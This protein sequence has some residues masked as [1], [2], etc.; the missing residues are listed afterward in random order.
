VPPLAEDDAVA[1]LLAR[2]A[3]LDVALGRTDIVAELC[4][5][6][7]RLPLALEL[8]AARTPLFTPAQLV[9]RLSQRLDLLKGGR[10]ATT[11][12]PRSCASG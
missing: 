1:L 8:A 9:E 5:R 4:R 10:D 7:D 3:S 12:R 6:L 11:S 2:A